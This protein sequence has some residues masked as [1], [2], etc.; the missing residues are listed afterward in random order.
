MAEIIVRYFH[1]FGIILLSSM[2]ITQNVL[3]TKNINRETILRLSRIDTL[4]GLGAIITLLCGLLLWFAVGKSAAY[5]NTN[6]LLHIKVSLFVLIG[7]LSIPPTIF[8]NRNRRRH[9]PNIEIPNKIIRI[10]RLELLGL[11][12][13][14]LL[15]VLIARGIGLR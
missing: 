8:L 3:L 14:P 15:A 10:K 11:L 7:L 1:F 2:L 12:I 4:Y 5:Y 13:M 6:P 9:E